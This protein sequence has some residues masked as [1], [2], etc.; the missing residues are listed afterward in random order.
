M[1]RQELKDLIK[2][3]I[4]EAI[5][6]SKASD[7]EHSLRQK[8]DEMDEYTF[9]VEFEFGPLTET[10]YI[11]RDEIIEKLADIYGSRSNNGQALRSSFSDW[12]EN[13][14]NDA[15]KNWL[16]RHGTID[17]IDEYD[18]SYGPMS[19]DD[20]TDNFPEPDR[21]NFNSEESYNEAVTEWENA[22]SDI[23]YNYRQWERRG[24]GD[25][26]VEDYF[27]LLSRSG[28]WTS[29]IDEREFQHV[30]MDDSIKEAGDYID[31]LGEDV[32]LGDRADKNT[33]AVGEDGPNVEI[34]SRHMRQTGDDFNIIKS[35]GNWVSEQETSGKTGMHIHIGMPKDF[36][37]FDLIAMTTLVDEDAVRND[38]SLD[39]DFAQFAQFRRSLH[40]RLV[41]LFVSDINEKKS[42]IITNSGV[43]GIMY[44]LNRNYGTNIKAFEEHKTVEFRYLGSNIA[45]KVLKWIQ[46]FLLLP[47]IAKSKN[48][49]VMKDIYG[50][51]LFATRM[52]GKIKFDY[53]PLNSKIT[54]VPMPSEPA[55]M[56]KQQYYKP[57]TPFEKAKAE[58]LK[59]IQI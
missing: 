49:V 29:Y 12:L 24:G 53:F 1:K 54:R 7:I 11:S 23:R 6:I 57:P 39:R 20:F 8:Y 17:S 27:T 40:N 36:D 56:I 45:D 59:S 52:P 43:K 51:T 9:G 26:F 47:R 44:S 25:Q 19:E 3:L 46:Y 50:G 30:D 16:R 31:G 48:Q 2:K 35:V 18:E 58:K 41:Q 13:E 14:R 33:W 32:I 34:R 5:P 38:S 37:V 10:Q 42:F 15:L 28:D 4:S 21:Q 22:V 55:D